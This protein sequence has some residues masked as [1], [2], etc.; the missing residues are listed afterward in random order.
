MHFTCG[1]LAI[2]THAR[3]LDRSGNPIPGLFAAG[4]TT[5]GIHGKDR[6]GGNSLIDCFVFGRIAGEEAAAGRK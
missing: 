5:G 1:G 6:L 3:V 4:E 2:D